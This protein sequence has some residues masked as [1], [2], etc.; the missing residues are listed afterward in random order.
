M[1]RIYTRSP[2]LAASARDL[3]CRSVAWSRMRRSLMLEPEQCSCDAGSQA[4]AFVKT[5][6]LLRVGRMWRVEPSQFEG[7]A[8]EV[9]KPSPP[10]KCDGSCVGTGACTADRSARCPL[11]P[12]RTPQYAGPRVRVSFPGILESGA[13][14]DAQNPRRMST[15]RVLALSSVASLTTRRICTADPAHLPRL[16]GFECRSSACQDCA[17]SDSQNPR[18]LD[19]SAGLRC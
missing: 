16:A 18:L 17:G 3:R 9:V 1:R 11:R 2:R 5:I 10:S 19:N 14:S 13:G 12:T 6:P 8:V 4:H 7:C 15:A